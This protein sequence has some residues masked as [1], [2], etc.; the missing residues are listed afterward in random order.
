M[1]LA[2]QTDEQFVPVRYQRDDGEIF[3]ARLKKYRQVAGGFEEGTAP[4]VLPRGFKMREI[5]FVHPPTGR[6]TSVPWASIDA[7]WTDPEL[8]ISIDGVADWHA[9]GR[10]GEKQRYIY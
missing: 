1:S 8:T 7:Q 10:S 5:H 9:T 2:D 4:S 3:T 6:R